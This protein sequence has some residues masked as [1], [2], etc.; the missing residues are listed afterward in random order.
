MVRSCF[1]DGQMDHHISFG[2]CEEEVGRQCQGRTPHLPPTPLKCFLPLQHENNAWS[3]LKWG[4]KDGQQGL[5][6][7]GCLAVTPSEDNRGHLGQA[8]H[9]EASGRPTRG[10]K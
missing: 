3:L 8:W 9:H 7:H 2:Q 4:G 10:K 1:D 6:R 5:H